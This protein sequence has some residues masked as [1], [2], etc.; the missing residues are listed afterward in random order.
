MLAWLKSLFSDGR[1][2]DWPKVRA[3]HLKKQPRCMACGSGK[4]LAV[5]H[6]QPFQ[7]FPQLELDPENLITLCEGDTL[8]CH[9]WL[10]HCGNFAKWY[11]PKVVESAKR[12]RDML[13]FREGPPPEPIPVLPTEVKS[14]GAG[15]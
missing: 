6:K 13:V 14:L 5:H 2:K 11:N 15:G 10:G 4:N 8:N 3:A 7:W 9:L 12:F 1:S